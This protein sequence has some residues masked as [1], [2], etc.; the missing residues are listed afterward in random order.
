MST[1]SIKLNYRTINNF[2]LIPNNQK[3]QCFLMKKNC[4]YIS[5][6]ITLVTVLLTF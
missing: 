4:F 6:F 1:F 3:F 2:D 5:L